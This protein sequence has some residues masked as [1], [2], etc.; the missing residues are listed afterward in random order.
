M[1][2][3]LESLQIKIW[4]RYVSYFVPSSRLVIVRLHMIHILILRI[5]IN[6]F[7]AFHDPC[8][9]KM[10]GYLHIL[11]ITIQQRETTSKRTNYFI[12]YSFFAFHTFYF[13][14][15]SIFHILLLLNQIKGWWIIPNKSV[16]SINHS[17]KNQIS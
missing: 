3:Y 2:M 16:D 17:N 11:M 13:L 4:W 6:S 5:I 14:S 15:Y 10:L 12:P 9:E 8:C 7:A 1:Q